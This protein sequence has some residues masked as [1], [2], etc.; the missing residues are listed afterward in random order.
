L[1]SQFASDFIIILADDQGDSSIEMLA[2]T[3]VFVACDS[4]FTQQMT[5]VDFE[6][7]PAF[8]FLPNEALF[9]YYVDQWHRERGLPLSITEMALC[10]SHFSIIAM[11]A[12]V[13]L[14]LIL[15]KM[16]DEDDEPD[17]WFVALQSLTNADPVTDEIRGDFKA[18]ADR[19]LQ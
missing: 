7:M 12:A 2:S 6:H 17:M 18:M 14:P 10:R 15:R 16:E 11:G 9:Q 8:P 4:L 5:F 1:L 13:A 3:S 19:W